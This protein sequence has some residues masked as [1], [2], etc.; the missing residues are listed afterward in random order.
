MS[1][2]LST[3]L[4]VLVSALSFS[5]AWRGPYEDGLRAA[6]AGSWAAAREAFM[7]AKAARP[8]DQSGPT[9]LPGPVTEQRQWRRGA[10][11]SPNFLAAYALYKHALT[12]SGDEM[13]AEL[14]TAA[15]EFEAILAK[16]QLS[17]EAFYFLDQIYTRTK[18]QGARVQLEAKFQA[19][20]PLRWRVDA[21]GINPEDQAEV[22]ATFRTV[23]DPG[24]GKTGDVAPIIRPEGGGVANPPIISPPV[25]RVPALQSKYALLIGNSTSKLADNAVP[26][27][28]ED[29]IVLRDALVANGGYP[30]EN[31]VVLTNATAAQIKATAQSLGEKISEGATVFVYFG[32]WGAHIDGRDYLAGVDAS[33]PT[34]T[35]SMLYKG[36]LFMPFITKGARIFAFFE[37]NRP[38]AMGDS[39]GM[40]TPL[41]GA[42]AQTYATLR[43]QNVGSVVRDGKQI[44]VFADA[45]AS[46]LMDLKS[47]QI[48]ILEFGW[49][50]F[51]KIRRGAG[52]YGGS[53]R[54]TPTLPLLN[55]LASDAR[56]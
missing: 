22:A 19:A 1:R 9:S 51:Y 56:F 55:N 36:D 29:T 2:S 18:D 12:L 20:G 26:F 41:L 40:E 33:M 28:A 17:R 4:F 32:G 46:V 48:P 43:G 24:P 54:Q 31:I 5:Q 50:L 13:N 14:R 45:I 3:L 25:G 42:V 44:G 34:D 6:K 21:D 11:Y 35:S 49:Q 16:G 47:N 7:S 23:A 8:E 15:G 10:P 37:T 52:S 53:S 27:A 39:F 30:E 38:E